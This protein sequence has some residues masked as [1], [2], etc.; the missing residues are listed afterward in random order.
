MKLQNIINEDDIKGKP[1]FQFVIKASLPG[2]DDGY[3][4]IIINNPI[5]SVSPQFLEQ[6]YHGSISKDI[7]ILIDPIVLS[8]EM[9]ND[10]DGF[11]LIGG[12]LN[13]FFAMIKCVLIFASFLQP[14]KIYSHSPLIMKLLH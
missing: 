5:K 7:L 6:I 4:A 13:I 10:A 11:E 12:Q 14:V 1:I 9:Y 8:T 2:A 3:A